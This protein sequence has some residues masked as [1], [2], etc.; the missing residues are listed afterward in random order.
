MTI[1]G[2]PCRH[3][4]FTQPPGDRAG[5]L[6]REEDKALPRRLVVTYRSEPGQPSYV[7]ELFDWNFS[8]HPTDADFAFQPPEGA[9][10][11][12]DEAGHH[13]DPGQSRREPSHE[14]TDSVS[15]CRGIGRCRSRRR[16]SPGARYM[17]LTAALP[18]AALP[19]AS[20]CAVLAAPLPIRGP[21]GATAYRGP[22]GVTAYHGAGGYYGYRPPAAGYYPGAAVRRGWPSAPLR[23]TGRPPTTR[24]RSWS[25]RRRAAT[26][27]ILPV[28]E[29][30]DGNSS[31]RRPTARRP[32]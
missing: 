7:A 19:A 27:R 5:A 18:I 31:N 9:T 20:P 3:L 1:D 4:L 26:T 16:R 24:R 21:A 30:R 32:R 17:G 25:H 11:V 13:R 23:P 29:I 28:I 12:R 8:I 6:D 10:Q 2:V 14:T 22:G 15:S